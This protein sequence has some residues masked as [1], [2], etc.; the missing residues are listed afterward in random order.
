MKDANQVVVELPPLSPP[1]RHQVTLRHDDGDVLVS[2]DGTAS[3]NHGKLELRISWNLTP[4]TSGTYR[5][6]L[7]GEQDSVPYL[8]PI[9]LR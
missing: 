6:G 3:A 2:A 7:K 4:L 5:L 8:Y 9:Q 1:G